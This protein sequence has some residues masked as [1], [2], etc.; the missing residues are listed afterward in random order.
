VSVRH[1][2]VSITRFAALL[3]WSFLGLLAACA[4]R[5][6]GEAPVPSRGAD[7]NLSGIWEWR[8]EHGVSTG[9]VV[10]FLAVPNGWRGWI[11]Q[12]PDS[13]RDCP[14]ADHL[15]S[16]LDVDPGQVNVVFEHL[17]RDVRVGP[18]RSEIRLRLDIVNPTT[19]Q[20]HMLVQSGNDQVDFAYPDRWVK[21]SLMRKRN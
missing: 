8:D 5:A 4:P 2:A 3:S 14:W 19:L 9:C 13:E 10:N 20:G 15:Q 6:T 18:A 1:S 11:D 16:H 21:I 7:F 12:D 17:I